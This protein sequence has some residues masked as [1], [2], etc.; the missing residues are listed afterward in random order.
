M[1]STKHKY[2]YIFVNIVHGQIFDNIFKHFWEVYFNAIKTVSINKN[3]GNN[4]F[5]GHLNVIV[6]AF[7][8]RKVL[9]T[10]NFNTLCLSENAA[11]LSSID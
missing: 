2:K 7:I 5:N 4:S 6:W 11:K 9:D 3:C 1:H 10:R 8:K